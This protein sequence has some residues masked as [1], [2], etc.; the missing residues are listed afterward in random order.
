MAP[1]LI[2][3]D[4]Y[5]EKV[6]IW[7]FGITA[8]ELADGEPPYLRDPVR[9]ALMDITSKPP[10]T[11]R[12]PQ[13]WSGTFN[14]F[15]ASCLNKCPYYRASASKLL[16]HEFIVNNVQEDSRALYTGFL[17]N[18]RPRVKVVNPK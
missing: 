11:L 4:K 12:R 1:E 18:W 3:G 5:N 13:R 16:E 7:S 10:P 8:I 17:Q 2:T 9:K 14:H 6:D 15:I